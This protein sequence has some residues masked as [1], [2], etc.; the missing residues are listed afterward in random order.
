MIE[1]LWLQPPLA[2]ARLGPST[3]PCDNYRWGPS[4]L[5]PRGT[6]RTTVVPDLTLDLDA[7]GRL[8]A[9][10]PERVRFKDEAG[11]RPVCPYFEVHGSWTVD[12]RSGEGPL[13][14]QI[15]ADSGLSLAD[16]R[17]EVSVANLKAHHLTQRAGDRIEARVELTGDDN[18]ARV[19][20][21]VSPQD[22]E[23]PLVPSGAGLPL[24]AVQLPVPNEEL[25]GL[26]LRFTPGTGAVYGPTNLR[27]PRSEADYDIPAARRILNP[28][29][30][31]V[32]FT[33]GDDDRTAPGNL[34][35]GA[36]F[37]RGLGLVDDVCDGTVTVRLPGGL[38][39]TARIVAAPPDF[40]PDRRP[41]VSLADG[42]ADRLKRE[43]VHTPGFVA[44]EQTALEI[45]DL[46]ERVL[47]TMVAVNVDVQNERS[48]NENARIAPALNV[49]PA[50][51]RALAFESPQPLLG[52][53]LALTERG[54]R[55]HRRFVALEVLEDMIRERRDLIP[56]WV[57]PPAEP[58]ADGGASLRSSRFYT[59]QMPSG[60]RGS[61]NY[62]LHLTRRQYDLLV[63]WAAQLAEDAE[64]NS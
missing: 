61:D 51:A 28:A 57:R 19:L 46:F 37:R 53:L 5:T 32:G 21:G 16:V 59:W 24:G 45:R 34:F 40:A 50:D 54:R 1:R 63:G 35:A 42:L 47:E 23:A 18:Q 29:S 27:D 11:W 3:V 10:M 36:E 41:F 60:M 2:F 26:R 17:W 33:L 30:R 48:G 44:D 6:G 8:S 12:G 56:T 43:E 13:T 7:D 31:W 4:D 9:R 14:E 58:A 38:A 39:A 62:P 49:S 22:E 64:P 25:P 55:R 15:L 52:L 20:A